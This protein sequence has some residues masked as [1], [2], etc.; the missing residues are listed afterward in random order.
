M[1]R[2]T[3]FSDLATLLDPDY[4]RSCPAPVLF[5]QI[6]GQE[7]CGRFVEQRMTIRR[8]AKVCHQPRALVFIEV[9]EVTIEIGHESLGRRNEIARSFPDFGRTSR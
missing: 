1:L 7:V 3:L 5:V 6:D 2:T 8:V 4:G 9:F